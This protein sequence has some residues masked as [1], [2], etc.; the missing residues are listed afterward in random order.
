MHVTNEESPWACL[1]TDD[2]EETPSGIHPNAESREPAQMEEAIGLEKEFNE[3]HEDWEGEADPWADMG[4]DHADAVQTEEPRQ[5][6][7]PEGERPASMRQEAD[8][9]LP[10]GR[11]EL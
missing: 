4:M 11:S 5:N 1:G 10:H 2:A 7:P 6:S 8:G 3:L 9:G